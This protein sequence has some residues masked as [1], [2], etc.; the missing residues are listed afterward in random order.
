MAFEIVLT[1]FMDF[2]QLAV[3]GPASLKAFAELVTTVERESHL[4]SDRKVLVDLREVEGDLLPD[5]QAFL[6]ELVAHHFQHLDKVASLVPAGQLTR[7]SERAAREMGMQLRVFMSKEEA[8]AWLRLPRT[9]EPA[10][11]ATRI[12]A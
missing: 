11:P 4:W 2:V 1:R 9:A 7:N 5:E 12:L 10:T 8:L 6:G 3:A